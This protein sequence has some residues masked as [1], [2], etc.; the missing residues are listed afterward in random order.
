MRT[1]DLLHELQDVDTQLE[2]ARVSLAQIRLQL[3]ERSVLDVLGRELTTAREELH[4]IDAAQRDLELEADSLRTKIADEEKRLYGGRITN[5]KELGSLSEEIAQ[6]KRRLN[7][8]EDKILALLE[9]GEAVGATVAKLEATLAQQTESWNVSQ[10][11]ARRRVQDLE[12]NLEA[13]SARR[14]ALAAQVDHTARALYDNLRRQ[15][16]GVAIAQVLQRTC[17]ACRVGLTPALEQRARI[18][19]DLVPCHSCGRIL[20]IPIS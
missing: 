15:K 9:D 14:E 5:P 10:G 6:E 16:G 18:G 8:I 12:G 4:R 7:G 11:Q 19:T 17:Q 2:G 1:I 20:Y 13:Y 3:G